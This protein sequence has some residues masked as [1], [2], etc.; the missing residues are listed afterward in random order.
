MM[1]YHALYY[2]FSLRFS[3]KKNLNLKIMSKAYCLDV[4]S[5][6][7]SPSFHVLRISIDKM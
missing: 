5:K 7:V 3:F 2:S 4:F 6:Y 1:L